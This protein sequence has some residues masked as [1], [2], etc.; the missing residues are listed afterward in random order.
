MVFGSVGGV[1]YITW[2]AKR[3]KQ[4]VQHPVFSRSFPYVSM[5][6]TPLWHNDPLG[7]SDDKPRANNPKA[8]EKEHKKR[9]EN[10]KRPAPKP[11]PAPAAASTAAYN[12]TN[13]NSNLPAPASTPTETLK[14]FEPNVIEQFSEK[15]LE[16]P[17]ATVS[18]P[19]S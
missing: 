19:E 7:N 11:A 14:P 9:I 16:T 3:E 17:S 12:T 18:S 4:R 15:F 1:H 6:N 5:G 8:E 10:N 2:S 13:P